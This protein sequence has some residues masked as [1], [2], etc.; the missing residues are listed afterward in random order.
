M[1]FLAPCIGP[2]SFS[3]QPL[4]FGSGGFFVE[5]RTGRYPRTGLLWQSGRRQFCAFRSRSLTRRGH[6][7]IAACL[8]YRHPRFMKL[9]RLR[10]KRRYPCMA[11][12]CRS[13]RMS[14]KK[15]GPEYYHDRRSLASTCLLFYE[16]GKCFLACHGVTHLIS[17]PW[18]LYCVSRCL[19]ENV[20]GTHEVFGLRR[21]NNFF[22]HL[23]SLGFELLRRG[24]FQQGRLPAN[25]PSR[26]MLP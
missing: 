26:Q 6:R 21:F 18:R 12:I 9:I 20:V 15:S 22:I 17:L 2:T 13:G 19:A 3:F 8:H 7:A 5:A 23:L 1:P 24:R 14:R 4:T 11:P 25:Y 16:G 10:R